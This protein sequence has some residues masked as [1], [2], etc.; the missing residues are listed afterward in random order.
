MNVSKLVKIISDIAF[1]SG[2]TVAGLLLFF[3]FTGRK[4][5]QLFV[6][7]SGSMETT[8]NTGSV[9][10]VSPKANYEFE[11]VITFKNTGSSKE[12]TTHRIVGLQDGQY[13]TGGDANDGMDQGLVDP[14]RVIGAVRASVPYAGYI[15]AFAKTP[16]GFIFL[17]IVPATIIIYE[18]LKALVKELKKVLGKIRN[19]GEHM[20]ASQIGARSETASPR[21]GEPGVE[22]AQDE[23]PNARSHRFY[24]KP[25]IVI[26]VFFA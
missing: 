21:S 10:I 24:L 16:P 25:A 9:V 12:T 6:V 26:P 17:V 13:K 20:E 23:M 2:I 19:R 15:A 22:D 14:S 1:L 3:H 8:I 11:D 18:E 4:P 7:T 5:F